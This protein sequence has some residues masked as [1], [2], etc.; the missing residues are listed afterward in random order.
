MRR[1]RDIVKADHGYI[2]RHS[3]SR[4]SNGADG[5]QRDDVGSTEYRIE[6]F[7]A[8]DNARIAS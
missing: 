4:S 7:A 6:L 8:A 1:H 5:T 3:Q 2:A